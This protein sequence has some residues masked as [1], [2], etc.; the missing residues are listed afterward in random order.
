MKVNT[1]TGLI[2]HRETKMRD[3]CI[4]VHLVVGMS[5]TVGQGETTSVNYVRCSFHCFD[6]KDVVRT[7]MTVHCILFRLCKTFN[8]VML[9]T[10]IVPS[11]RYMRLGVVNAVAGGQR[12][13]SRKL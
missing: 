2:Q 9:R 5:A 4:S 12:P 3:A 10:S 7:R 1:Q 13:P 8:A 11:L 6:G